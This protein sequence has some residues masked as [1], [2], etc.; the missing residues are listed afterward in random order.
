MPLPQAGS[1]AWATVDIPERRN[2]LIKAAMIAVPAILLVGG[3]ALWLG[4]EQAAEPSGTAAT[5]KPPATSAGADPSGAPS[6][7]PSEGASGGE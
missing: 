5:V 1:H 3:I 2:G 4:M 6:G 7:E